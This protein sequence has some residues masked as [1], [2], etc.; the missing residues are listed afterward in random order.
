MREN[1]PGTL[2]YEINRVLRP[3]K[4]GTEDIVM[5]ERYANAFRSY[6]ED[7][8]IV[9]WEL[10]NIDCFQIQRS[11]VVE[12]PWNKRE[13]HHVPE[14][15]GRGGSDACANAAEDGF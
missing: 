12:D 5:I 3:A 15:A 9:C 1:E 10:I 4:D 2:K 7:G 8:S 6:R 11:A 14:E 13:V